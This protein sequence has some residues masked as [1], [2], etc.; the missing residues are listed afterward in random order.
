MNIVSDI[1]ASTQILPLKPMFTLNFNFSPSYSSTLPS[2]NRSR[3]N[4]I[5][6]S[7]TKPPFSSPKN[8]SP[9][10]Q[11]FLHNGEMHDSLVFASPD[12]EL[13]SITLQYTNVPST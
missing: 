8:A 5:G 4:L 12:A 2:C 3:Q 7:L 11:D 6:K 10:F 9:E 13:A 1:L